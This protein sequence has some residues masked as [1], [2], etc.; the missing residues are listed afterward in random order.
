MPKFSRIMPKWK[1]AVFGLD[2]RQAITAPLLV[3]SSPQSS[4]SEGRTDAADRWTEV[5]GYWTRHNVTNHHRFSS[6]EESLEF[7]AWRNDQY[8]G[9]IDL[10]PVAGYDSR[11]ILDYGCGPGHDVVGFCQ[12]SPGSQVTGVDVSPSSLREAQAR[13]SLHQAKARLVQLE[14]DCRTLPFDGASFDVV[15]SSGV[16]HHMP[17]PTQTMRELRRVISPDG[18]AQ[19]MVYNYDSIWT[20]LYVAYEKMLVEGLYADLDIRQAF[21]RTTDGPDC[22]IARPYRPGEFGQVC[23]DAGFVVERVQAAVSVWELSLL[24]KRY[25]AIMERRLAPESRRFLS[26]LRFDDRG[27]PS[28][29]GLVAGIDL[30]F[31][32]RAA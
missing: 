9:Y 31:L 5:S 28:H 18:V 23:E 24:P 26:E 30:C 17:D 6:L 15:H 2:P 22:P 8:P 3:R 29:E 32:L 4:T 1:H 20:H 11:R 10:M 13:I 25:N 7:F 14:P 16:L 19:I 12:F 27:V 21:A